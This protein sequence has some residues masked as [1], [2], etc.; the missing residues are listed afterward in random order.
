[1]IRTFSNTS[2]SANCNKFICKENEEDFEYVNKNNYLQ[3]LNH[4]ETIHP[5]YN[6]FEPYIHVQTP[7]K[8]VIHGINASQI[9]SSNNQSIRFDTNSNENQSSKHNI[10]PIEPKRIRKNQVP[11]HFNLYDLVRDGQAHLWPSIIKGTTRFKILAIK[12][13]RQIKY[14]Q[15]VLKHKTKSSEVRAHYPG[16]LLNKY[17]AVA[18]H[19]RDGYIKINRQTLICDYQVVPRTDLESLYWQ[20]YHHISNEKGKKRFIRDRVKPP[21]L[22]HLKQSEQYI[23]PVYCPYKKCD[24]QNGLYTCFDYRNLT[25]DLPSPNC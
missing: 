21:V 23:T 17:V 11:K 8:S 18:E 22:W 4:I 19:A 12:D 3:T 6:H 5:R 2:I 14:N 7:G 24:G 15:L 20:Q 9:K 13:T 25:L 10:K 1:M 16:Q